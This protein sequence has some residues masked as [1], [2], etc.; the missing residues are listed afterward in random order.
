MFSPTWSI[1]SQLRAGGCK[2]SLAS[3]AVLALARHSAVG[4]DGGAPAVHADASHADGAA[5]VAWGAHEPADVGIFQ[6]AS[7]HIQLYDAARKDCN[8]LHLPAVIQAVL[9]L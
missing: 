3:L 7:V 1:R 6:Q 9:K 2:L 8:N 4:T 5:G